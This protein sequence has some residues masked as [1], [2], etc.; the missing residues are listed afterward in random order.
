MQIK[1]QLDRLGVSLIAVGKGDKEAAMKFKKAINWEAPIYLDE[2]QK[3]F[4][5]ISLQRWSLWQVTKRFFSKAVF[6]L[7]KKYPNADSKGDGTQS[8]AILLLGPGKS[9]PQYTFRENEHDLNEF[10]DNDQI[11][12]AAGRKE[13]L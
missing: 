9:R 3:A 7:Y 1:P 12:K 13:D 10:A 2:E 4:K 8:G 11:L 6:S 5:A